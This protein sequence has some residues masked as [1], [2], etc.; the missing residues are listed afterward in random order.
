MLLKRM[1]DALVSAAA[2]LLLAPV[3]AVI[4]LAVW[5]ET[6]RPLLYSQRRIGRHFRQFTMWKFRSMYRRVGGSLLTASGDPRVTKVGKVIRATKLDE[7]PQLWNV[8]RGDMSLVGPRPEVAQYVDLYRER[9]EPILSLR[10]G[11]TDMAS[12]QFC[13]EEEELANSPDPLSEYVTTVLP[14]KLCLAEQ[15]V[16][17]RSFGLDLLILAQTA[18]AILFR[19]E[20]AT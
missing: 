12:I 6:G 20:V 11:I 14:A 16:A 4:G 8:L 19:R 13:R 2:L 1:F 15:Y 5:L 7:L 18:A 9:F 3:F 10:P 17:R